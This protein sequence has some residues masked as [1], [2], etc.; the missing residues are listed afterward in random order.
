MYTLNVLAHWAVAF[1]VVFM[2]IELRHGVSVKGNPVNTG[3]NANT[4][5]SNTQVSPRREG[6]IRP[7]DVIGYMWHGP[8]CINNALSHP[9]I[10]YSSNNYEKIRPNWKSINPDYAIVVFSDY[11]CESGRQ[12]VAKDSCY[13]YPDRRDILC[14]DLTATRRAASVANVDGST[15]EE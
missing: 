13:T 12:Y 2:T 9:V 11:D 3:P 8:D 5:V 14:I 7:G 1:V 10:H 4:L 6:P 15:A